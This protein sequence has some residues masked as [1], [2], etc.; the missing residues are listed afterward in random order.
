MRFESHTLFQHIGIMSKNSNL[1]KAKKVKN[2]EFYTRYSDICKEL[3]Y[4]KSQFRGKTVY[5]NCDSPYISNFWKY[6][7]RNFHRLKLK[8]LTSTYKNTGLRYKTFFNGSSV[9]TLLLYG[10]GDFNSRE[11][12][13]ILKGSDIVV[14]NPP[15]SLFTSYV[16]LLMEYDKK[17]LI[18][19]NKNALNCREIF[20]WFR[21]NRLWLGYGS[22][23]GFDS[24]LGYVDMKGL[25]RWFTN[26]YTFKRNDFLKLSKLYSESEYLKY[27][28]FNAIEVSRVSDIPKDYEG[29]M[30][31]PVTF[32]D[33]Y[34]PE[35]FEILGRSGDTEWVRKECDF[36]TPPSEEKQGMYKRYDGN[37][38]VQNSYLLNEEGMPRCIYYRV[39]IRRKKCA[40]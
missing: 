38:R 35:Q 30:G 11:C 39:F 27:E 21:D 36:F 1:L 32:L 28:N 19:G 12:I 3:K 33:V 7:Q 10:D 23:E 24:P 25:C 4:Y 15:F 22:P 13:N 40:E 16:S 18:L 17:F 34:N 6:F 2:D 20:R 31:V 29:V 26:L 9:E 14:T 37:W 8:G 5:C